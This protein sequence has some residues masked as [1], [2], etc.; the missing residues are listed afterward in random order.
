MQS[1]ED[2]NKLSVMFL[3]ASHFTIQGNTSF[4]LHSCA[5]AAAAAAIGE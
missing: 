1:V 4:A 5:E 2:L 3:Q